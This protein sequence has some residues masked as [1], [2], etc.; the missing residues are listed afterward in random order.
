MESDIGIAEKPK[1]Q[2]KGIR[3]GLL[4]ILEDG[5]WQ[6]V[7]DFLLE[8]I[9]QQAEFLCGAR[10]ALDVG[11]Q[12]LK[13]ADLGQLRNQL[14][15]RK[16]TLWA[17]ISDSP[18]TQQTA[19]TLGMEIQLTKAK[20]E[21]TEQS[22]SPGIQSG[23]QAILLHRTLRSGF[24]IQFPGH[25]VVIGDVNPGAEIIAGGNIVIWGRLRGMAHAGA[26]G[27]KEAIICALDVMPTQLRIADQIS[28]TPQ[29][30]KK[31]Q[32]EIVRLRDG[33]VIAELWNPK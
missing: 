2:I 15:D 14:S 20:P 8:Q 1:I 4:I 32:P 30:R 28:I 23:E 16:I 12:V 13:A 7:H 21:Q 11:S 24:S 31:A 10:V 6:K 9:D 3:E 18:T 25:V 29:Q 26:E 22:I 19:Q 33:S 5:D 17:V 27:N